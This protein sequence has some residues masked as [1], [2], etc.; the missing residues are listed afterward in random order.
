MIAAICVLAILVFIYLWSSCLL[1]YHEKAEELVP[2]E[3][4]CF[5]PDCRS[6][7][8]KKGNRN[9]VMMIHGYPTTPAMYKYASKRAELA[10]YDVHAPL[11]PTF[12]ADYHDFEKTN[13]SSWYN[14]IEK[15]YLSLEK[16]YD[17]V[18]VIGISMGGAMTLKL[19]ENHSPAAIAIIGAPVVYNSLFRDHVV[20]SWPSYIARIAGI[21]TPAIGAGIVTEKKDSNDGNEDW[22]G[23]K[24]LFPKQGASLVW[25]L[26]TIRKELGKIKVPMLSIHDRGDK[27]VPFAN[28]GIIKKETDTESEFIETEMSDEYKHSHHALLM[29]KSIQSE[30]MDRIL[31]F[32][33][34]HSL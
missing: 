26:R 7:V 14:W 29:Y 4:K 20:T 6:I 12:G 32:F 25:N 30:L 31:S 13:F 22:K 3:S 18:F 16:E 1:F 23:Y 11:I 27:T 24:G 19:A 33:Q 8:I 21:F 10:G 17:R 28:Q 9:A 2:D 15:Y 34:N 5:S